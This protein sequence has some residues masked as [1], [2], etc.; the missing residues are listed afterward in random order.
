MKNRLTTYALAAALS[1][2][3][4]TSCKKVDSPFIIKDTDLHF[5]VEKLMGT[6]ATVRVEPED[7]RSYYHFEVR[8]KES[9]DAMNISDDHFMMLCLDSLYRKFLDWRY[10]YL[11]ENEEYIAEFTSHGLHY[12]ASSKFLLQLEPNTDYQAIGFCVDPIT[13]KS[14]GRLQRFNFRTTETNTEYIS[15][16]QIDFS[17]EMTGS[18]QNGLLRIMIRPSEGGKATKESFIW[19]IVDGNVLDNQYGGNV[20]AFAGNRIQELSRDP[21]VLKSKVLV[22]ICSIQ[23][24]GLEEGKEYCIVASPYL[25]TWLH[26]LYYI[27]FTFELGKTIHYTHEKYGEE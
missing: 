24:T 13:R 20:A 1:L 3:L 26:S 23:L 10:P 17:L 8:K 4:S 9:M 5:S 2:L 12:G 19:D 7:Y 16:M 27:R 11:V 22:D 18:T 6:Q 14:C 15:K 21:E 25:I